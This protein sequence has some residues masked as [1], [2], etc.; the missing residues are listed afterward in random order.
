[1]QTE[2][3]KSGEMPLL[4]LLNALAIMDLFQ[5]IV[6]ETTINKQIASCNETCIIRS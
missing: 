5:R 3:P 6:Y 1:M 4:G 2:K